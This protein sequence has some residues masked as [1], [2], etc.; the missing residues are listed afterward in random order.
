MLSHNANQI[1]QLFL[2]TK[3]GNLASQKLIH[4][5]REVAPNPTISV[6]LVLKNGME[7]ILDMLC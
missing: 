6:P 5:A 4:V 2:D 7:N 3:T 1:L